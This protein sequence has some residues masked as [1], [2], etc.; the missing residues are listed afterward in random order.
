MPLAHSIACASSLKRWTVMTGPKTSR[1]ASSS[2]GRRLLDDRRLEEEARRVRLRPPVTSRAWSG[3]RS[4]KPATFARWRAELSGP[5]VVSGSAVSPSVQAAGL[6]GQRLDDVVVHAVG[7]EHARR[8]RAVLAGVVVA[9]AGDPGRH[10][11]EVGVVEHH[12]RRLAAELEVDALERVGGGARDPLAG[13]DRAGQRDHVDVR[14]RDQP[15][16]GLAGAG[17]D[18]QHALRQDL[19]RELAR[20]AASS[21]ASS[22][23]A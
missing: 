20:G 7:D 6:L 8:R 19:V 15:L 13:L 18:V 4:M 21:A 10:R 9:G 17:D 16:A 3:M 11:L 14:V 23:P 5:S 2:S 22:R 1:W 12:D